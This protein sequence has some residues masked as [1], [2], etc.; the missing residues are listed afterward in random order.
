[1]K[2]HDFG[3]FL[4]NSSVFD[5]EKLSKIIS[6]AK[7][8]RPTFSTAAIF[9]RL[10]SVNELTEIFA[11]TNFFDEKNSVEIFR[12]HSPEVQKKYD[13]IVQKFLN[14]RK[15]K[16]IKESLADP[17]VKFAQVLVDETME[18]SQFEKVLEE[19][20]KGEISPVEKIFAD[21]Y[22]ALPSKMNF[23]YPP[24]LEVAK[25]FHEFLS[26]SLKTT[27]IFSS[28]PAKTDEKLFG[29]S[30][31][32]LGAI[33][34][35]VGVVAEKNVLHKLANSYD[36]FISEDIDEDFDSVAEMLNVFTGNFTVKVASQL[37]IEEELF[38]PLVGRLEK[39][40]VPFLDVVC[41]F[42]N[43]YLYIGKEEIFKKV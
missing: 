39:N 4:F 38:P 30:V 26:D 40:E 24:A 29:A 42:G 27:I 28:T 35:I 21:W 43:F 12:S 25:D 23:D 1:M 9:F 20:Y 36:K 3:Q 31:K 2:C 8:I 34:I 33:P 41:D 13:E 22:D 16:D 10:V 7:K 19:F 11:E 17:S 32:I 6:A 5:A 37:G 14:P 18:F 15:V